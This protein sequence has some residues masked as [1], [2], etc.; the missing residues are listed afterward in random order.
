MQPIRMSAM[1][2]TLL[3]LIAAMLVLGFWQA[4][5]ARRQHGAA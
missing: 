2:K 5:A 4:R 1:E 3:A